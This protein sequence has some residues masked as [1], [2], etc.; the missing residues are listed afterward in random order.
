MSTFLFLYQNCS[1]PLSVF[2]GTPATLIFRFLW[3][4]LYSFSPLIIFCLPDC[5]F[6]TSHFIFELILHGMTSLRGTDIEKTEIYDFRALISILLSLGTYS[7]KH[8][9]FRICICTHVPTRIVFSIQISN[10]FISQSDLS[11]QAQ[12]M[13]EYNIRYIWL[14]HFYSSFISLRSFS[15]LSRVSNKQL[16]EKLPSFVLLSHLLPVFPISS[17]GNSSPSR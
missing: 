4:L 17:S 10:C 9:G 12:N 14:N 11:R 7:G 2:R 6:L 8:S 5:C 1:E 13:N 16:S 15:S 3:K